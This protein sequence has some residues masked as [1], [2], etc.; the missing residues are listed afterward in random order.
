M[1]RVIAQQSGTAGAQLGDFTPFG[2]PFRNQDGPDP[3]RSGVSQSPLSNGP[4]SYTNAQR[5]LSVLLQPASGAG[6]NAEWKAAVS[7][8]DIG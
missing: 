7:W 5:Y 6:A 3:V 2:Q 4:T 1:A 8:T